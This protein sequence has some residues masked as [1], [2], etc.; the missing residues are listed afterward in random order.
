MN[1][2]GAI[3]RA[4]FAFHLENTVQH[5]VLKIEEFACGTVFLTYASP[6]K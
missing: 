1:L 3:N 6:M 2:R 4:L 5:G